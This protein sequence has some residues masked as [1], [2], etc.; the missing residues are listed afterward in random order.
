MATLKTHFP[1]VQLEAIKELVKSNGNGVSA[2]RPERGTRS[3]VKNQSV[4][5]NKARRTNTVQPCS[6]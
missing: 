6:A 5:K 3:V 1:R 2:T 4:V